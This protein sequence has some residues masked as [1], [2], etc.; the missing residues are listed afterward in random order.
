VS[1]L[2]AIAI[3]ILGGTAA[4]LLLRRDRVRVVFGILLLG[5]AAVLFLFSTGGLE[6]RKAPLVPLGEELPPEPFAD[7]LPQALVLT[8]I[9]IA[10]ALQAFALALMTAGARVEPPAPEEG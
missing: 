9:V 10:F 4:W 3:G 2:T 6:R 8:A 5:Q 1:A 7:P